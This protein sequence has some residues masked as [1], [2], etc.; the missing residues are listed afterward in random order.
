RTEAMEGVP[1]LQQLVDVFT[2]D[3][4]AFTLAI[5]SVGPALVRPLIPVEVQPLERGEDVLL[6]LARA[7]YLIGI[8]DAQNEFAAVLA[9][10]AEVEQRDVRGAHVRIAGGRRRNAGSDFRH[11]ALD[12]IAGEKP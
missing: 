2:V 8:L 3:G 4:G 11:E 9:G 10:E 6:R 1:L 7:A 12:R 5:R